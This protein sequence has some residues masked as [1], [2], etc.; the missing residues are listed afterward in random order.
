MIWWIIPIAVGFFGLVILMTAF[1]RF[2]KRKVAD[3]GFRLLVGGMVLTGAALL[4]LLGLNL[5]TYS[6]LNHERDVATI[7]LRYLEDQLY[8]ASLLLDGAEIPLVF[9]IRGDEVEMKARV[10]KWTRWT[11][12]VGYDSIYKLDRIAGQYTSV[13]EDLNKPRTVYALQSG[14]GIDAFQLVQ[15]RGGWLKAVDAYYGS[16]TYVPMVDGAQYTIRMT[17]SGLISRPAND[18]AR[19]GLRNWSSAETSGQE[20]D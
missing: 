14:E 15:K 10:I 3:G 2:G 16:G 6:R 12:I 17:Q 13:E 11:N 8:E 5:Q 20:A 1:G 7:E 19:T 4:A 9:N 18:V